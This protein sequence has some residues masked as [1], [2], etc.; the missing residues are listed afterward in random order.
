MAGTLVDRAMSPPRAGEPSRQAEGCPAVGP[1]GGDGLGSGHLGPEALGASLPFPAFLMIFPLGLASGLML[2]RPAV[3]MPVALSSLLP[4]INVH[5]ELGLAEKTLS[6]D[7]LL[8]PLHDSDLGGEPLGARGV[9]DPPRFPSLSLWVAWL[10]VQSITLALVQTSLL[11]QAWY[12]TEQITYL[13]FFLLA[14]D[15]L[16]APGT[17][18]R[19]L[20]VLMIGGWIVASLGLAQEFLIRMGGPTIDL[21]YPSTG[22]YATESGSTIGQPNFFSAFQILTLPLTAWAWWQAS[23]WRRGALSF[24]GLNPG[25][26]DLHG[27]EHRWGGGAWR[28]QGWWSCGG[29]G[30]VVGVWRARSSRPWGWWRSC[31]LFRPETPGASIAPSPSAPTSWG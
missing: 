4:L 23:G 31:G 27:Q 1:G 25:G 28:R 8:L 21:T 10:L 26:R 9:P 22:R 29:R 24:L 14:L 20:K 11:D 15:V 16:K 17:A 12:L 7:K 18:L 2:W 19:V 6:F 13:L 5:F 3:A 30:V